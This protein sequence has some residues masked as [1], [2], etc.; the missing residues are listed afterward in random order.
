M[1]RKTLLAPGVASLILSACGGGS[2]GSTAV[3]APVT[4]SPP[5][6]VSMGVSITGAV[7]APGGQL[8]FNSPNDFLTRLGRMI[9]G[10][11]FAGTT[12]GTF[13]NVGAG[14]TV[15][16][17]KVDTS[18]AQVGS[19]MANTTTLA[20]GSYT[21]TA[22]AGFVP[23]S[24]YVVRATST[25][26]TLDALVTGTTVNV[27]P[28]TNV[29][30]TLILTAAATSSTSLVNITPAEVT[31]VQAEVQSLTADSSLTYSS[32]SSATATL[33]ALATA[34]EELTNIVSNAVVTGSG[35]SG[36]VKDS[37]GA[38]LANVKVVAA[39]FGDWVNAAVALTDANGAFTMNVAPGDYIVGAIN[40]TTNTAAS[41]WWTADGAGAINK[42]SAGKV[43]VAASGAVTANFA[44]KAG[45]AVSGSVTGASS[46]LGD[47]QVQLRD[48][49]NDEP[50]SS[51][52]TA[53]DGSYR[54]NVRPGTY[55]LAAV[56]RTGQPF[57][58][59]YYG[60]TLVTNASAAI[61]VV[62][63]SS[64]LTANFA[65]PGG[66]KIEGTVSDPLT[67][68]VKGISVRFYDATAP[69]S[70]GAFINGVRT[71]LLGQYRLWLPAN[72]SY[73]VRA[74]GQA[75]AANNSAGDVTGLNFASH[76]AQLSGVML[77]A[78]NLPVSQAKVEV[79]DPASP[80][81][82]QGF[83][84]TNS[85]GSFTIY[86][87]LASIV[88][89][90]KVDGGMAVGSQLFGNN[91]QATQ[92]SVAAAAPVAMTLDSTVPGGNVNLP[93]GS[94]VSGVVTQ[95]SLPKG[96][97]VVQI[98]S[99]GTTLA[100]QFVSTRTQSDGSY[101][102]SLPAGSYSA[103]ACIPGGGTCSAFSSITVAS[104][105]VTKSFGL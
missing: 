41:E 65:L 68:V 58:S 37:S 70:T 50:V 30:T 85:D 42:F 60:S 67:G 23:S 10:T 11:A 66:N 62:A 61:P 103:R 101:S 38:P 2:G 104:T 15:S 49:T 8:A 81:A 94:V 36:V 43:T 63:G 34:N 29:T 57:A 77:D 89:A 71:D 93:A 83:E 96:N 72:T 91:V 86:S 98:R 76:V 79:Y 84:V 102:I 95:S 24:E 100:N 78:A 31:A 16:L 44:L 32:A 22:P 21:L 33:K 88:L 82:Y 99:G 92:M 25:S 53:A 80:Y 97:L 18:G 35:V 74:R 105:P 52:K 28:V 5:P 14:V 54:I 20:D 51:V 47:V 19:A 9:I 55:T 3:T 1:N 13:G 7:S 73:L 56:N 87:T 90:V 17:I 12:S 6:V 4:G 39:K 27:D 69:D 59:Q 75:L 64:A 48:F 45:V 26:G 46:P 40:A